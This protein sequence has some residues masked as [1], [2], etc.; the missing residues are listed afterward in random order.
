MNENEIKILMGVDNRYK[1][2]ARD[3]DNKMFLFETKP[4][5]RVV[6]GLWDSPMT[7]RDSIK[8]F[9]MFSHLFADVRWEDVEPLKIRENI[10][11]K[12][13]EREI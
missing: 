11:E 5:K 2:L 7:N 3:K 4:K 13:Q 9:S 1:Y 10:N 8:D 6:E 12:E